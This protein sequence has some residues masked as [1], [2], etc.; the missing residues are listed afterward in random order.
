[1]SER[2]QTEL[3]EKLLPTLRALEPASRAELDDDVV[4][5]TGWHISSH[6]L[7]G[8][9]CDIY[10]VTNTTC[11]LALKVYKPD[12]TSDAAPDIQYRALERCNQ[13]A[14][15]QPI[16]RAP[17]ALA[18]LPDERAILME[19]QQAGTLRSALWHRLASPSQRLNLIAAAGTW[20]RAF[21]TLSGI[22]MQPLDGAKLSAKLDTQMSRKPGAMATLNNCAAF[23]TALDRFQRKAAHTGNETPHALLHGDY[24]PTN[25]LVDDVGIIGMDMWG[26]RR[27]PI[28]EDLARMLTYLG[29]VSPFALKA[30]PLMPKS[31][32]VRA[33][34][35]GYGDDLLSPISETLY[36]ILLYQQL[37][38]WMVYADR[39]TS[40]PYSPSVQ[41]QLARNQHL[42]RQTLNWLDHCKT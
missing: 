32:L 39:K 28:F 7:H 1:M 4:F 3:L 12:M 22:T 29:V 20:L 42:C 34:A 19:W 14:A 35:Q 5:G 36:L 30:S 38:R 10:K 31:T 6:V 16:L 2:I 41:W 21:H 24:T 18:F 27:A 8:R 37:R 17:K 26:A 23:Q 9:K 11:T 15:N 40:R 25:L 33:F 13:A